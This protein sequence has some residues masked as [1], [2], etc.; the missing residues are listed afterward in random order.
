[1]V[2]SHTRHY[3]NERTNE[4][5][6]K[7]RLTENTLQPLGRRDTVQHLIMEC[8]K[9]ADIWLWTRTR[10]AQILRT[11]IHSTRLD[12]PPTVP[13][14]PPSPPPQRQGAILWTLAH[15]VYCR[16]QHRNRL[17]PANYADYMRRARWK[18]YHTPHRQNKVGNYLD[19]L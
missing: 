7:I 9:R 5:L 18:A 8:R 13:L 19:T 14:L 12:Y 3:T 15:T 10:I 11:D 6:I 4:R 2:H 17:F 1:M 16:I